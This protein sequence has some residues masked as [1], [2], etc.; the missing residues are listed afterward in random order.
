[1][2]LKQQHGSIDDE[3]YKPRPVT[4]LCR[5][6]IAV[7]AEHSS[8]IW[9]ALA[10]F[11]PVAAGTAIQSPY[12]QAHSPGV[13]DFLRT[14]LGRELPN[15]EYRASA[16]SAAPK[17]EESVEVIA[18]QHPR[19]LFRKVDY[20]LEGLLNFVDTGFIGLPDIQRPF[21]WT[22]TK[23]RDLFDSM[24]RGFPVG[25]LLFWSNQQVRGSRG[26]GL[27][28]KQH[29][30]SQLVVDGQQRLTSLYAVFTGRPVV[31]SEFRPARIEI[32]FRPRDGSFE[33]AD[34]PIRKDPEFIADISAF[35][36]SGRSSRSLINEFFVRLKARKSITEEQEEAISHNLDRLFDLKKYPFTAL[37]IDPSVDE[38]SVADIFVRINSEGVKL[39]QADFVLTLLSV[40]WDE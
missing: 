16:K 25:Y 20:D 15:A 35:W 5:L 23:V 28:A 3:N 32:A 9:P 1:M 12:H 8:T 18:F 19:T 22:P 2:D 37:E 40:F 26:I 39:N 17:T 30:P 27:G 11:I 21:V 38:E 7:A 14:A 4:T 34:A 24:Y 10:D 31:D 6:P 36:T 29:I 13:V 33:V